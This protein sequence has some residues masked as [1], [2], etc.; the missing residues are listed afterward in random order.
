L[1]SKRKIREKIIGYLHQFHGDRRNSDSAACG[2]STSDF[3]VLME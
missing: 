3:T 2:L 1:I